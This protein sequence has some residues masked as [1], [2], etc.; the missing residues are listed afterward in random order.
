[1]K[2]RGNTFIA[3]ASVPSRLFAFIADMLLI[4]FIILNPFKK[5]FAR[6]IPGDASY[7]FARSYMGQDT[8]LAATVTLLFLAIGILIMFYF[9]FFEYILKQTPGKMIF[10][11]YIVEERKASFWNYLFS[12]IIFIPVFPFILLWILDPIYIL[13]SPKSQRFME[14][15]NKIFVVQKYKIE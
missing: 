4:N 1:M 2:K 6:L 10:Q 13:T 11:L 9:T 5:I 3:P 14:K 8:G 7:D 15:I 12:N